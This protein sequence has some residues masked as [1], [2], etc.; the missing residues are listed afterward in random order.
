[1]RRFS[2]FRIYLV[3]AIAL[4]FPIIAGCGQAA[5]EGRSVDGYEPVSLEPLKAGNAG[6]ADDGFNWGTACEPGQGT[7]TQAISRRALVTIGAIPAGQ[8]D[9]VIALSSTSDLDVQ[10]Y[11]ADGTKLVGWPDGQLSGAGAQTLEY[12]GATISYSGYEGDGQNFGHETISISGVTPEA[13]SMGAYGFVA[14]DAQVNYSWEAPANC[15]N[16]G[17]GVFKQF[18]PKDQVV[19]VG[20]IPAGLQDVKITLTSLEDVDVQLVAADGTLLVH[21]PDGILKGAG[22]ESTSFNGVEVVY[23]GYNGDGHPGNEYIHLNG[24]TQN[25]FTMRAYGYAAGEATISYTFTKPDPEP[26]PEPTPEPQPSTCS[27][28]NDC[29]AG[30]CLVGRCATIQD[31][32][33]PTNY[34]IKYRR[35]VTAEWDNANGQHTIA[36]VVEYSGDQ[37][38]MLTLSLN[39]AGQWATQGFLSTH[40]NRSVRLIHTPT[41]TLETY[42]ISS[43]R[44]YR[45]TGALIDS[46]YEILHYDVAY[47]PNGELMLLTVNKLPNNSWSTKTQVFLWRKLNNVWTK[48]LVGGVSSDDMAFLRFTANNTPE[49]VVTARQHVSLWRKGIDAWA[50]T[51]LHSGTGTHRSSSYVKNVGGITSIFVGHRRFTSSNSVGEL[52]VDLVVVNDTGLVSAR[53]IFSANH[54]QAH[55]AWPVDVVVNENTGMTYLLI[56]GKH[57]TATGR[58]PTVLIADDGIQSVSSIVAEWTYAPTGRG[59]TF[60][61]S[62]DGSLYVS[63]VE[64]TDAPV[65]VRKITLN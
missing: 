65:V 22:M 4:T 18:I 64:A 7:F 59:I 41:G 20:V 42:E 32:T 35:G 8:T 16:S 12:G 55:G 19:D 52:E 14:G 53:T 30:Y 40:E 15:D 37:Y 27:T 31:S 47:A 23:S 34:R 44:V 21:W 6:K 24:V 56:E 1:M 49:V 29:S 17:E 48:D 25:D 26:V 63:K 2:A 33:T 38:P 43:R 62:P 3:S 10:L 13:L 45:G 54:A 61:G 51:L 11:A 60:A 5:K 58:R 39:S 28:D 9:V 57:N 46:G 36:G 50:S